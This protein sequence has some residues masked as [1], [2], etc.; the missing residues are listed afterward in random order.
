MS[1]SATTEAQVN[2]LTA[3]YDNQRT[4]ANLHEIILNQSNVKTG[5]FG[6][7]GTFPV[8]GEIYAQPL[9]VAG[10]PIQGQGIR[11]VVYIATNHN[12][13][14]AI[15]ADAT[16][17]T[18]PLWQVNLGPAVPSSVLS[19]TDVL[20]EVGILSTPVIDLMRQAIYV[21]ADTLENGVPVF[22]LHALSLSDGNE[23]LNGPI[24]IAAKVNGNGAGSNG[25]GTL[26]FDGSISLQR[27]GLVLANGLMYLGF[28]SRG[29]LG[30]W[31][32]WFIAYDASNLQHQVA[33]LNTSPNGFGA[34]I[35]QAGRAP[36]VDEKGTIYVVTGNGDFD[37]TAD[38]GESVLKLSGADLTLL[39]W[40]TPDTFKDWND[41][42]L[43]LGSTG[44]ILLPNTNLV[45]TGGKS[46][47][48]FL[49]DGASMGHLGAKNTST[50]QNI[51]ANPNGVFDMA[52]W[53]GPSGPIAYVQEPAGSLQAYQIVA[54]KINGTMLSH[55]APA[56]ATVFTGIAVSASSSTDPAAI[57]WETTADDLKVM[58]P[59]TLHAF[60]ATD[61]TH[62]LWNSDVVP[63]DA[64]GRFAKF[65][66]PTVA[67]GRVYVPTFSN[68]LAIYGLLSSGPPT[69]ETGQPQITAVTHGASFLQ[70][71]VSPGELVAIFGANLGPAQL[72]GL[73]VGGNG[74]LTT[75]LSSTR[76]F[77]DGVPSPLLYTSA[78]QVGAIVPFRITA[79]TQVQVQYQGQLSASVTIPVAPAAPALFSKDGT[80]GDLGAILNQ[81]GTPNSFNAPAARGSIVMM[82]ATGLGQTNP[83]G[84]DGQIAANLPLPAPIL[85][86]TVLIDNQP[87]EVLYAGAAPGMVQGVFQINARVPQSA[88]PFEDSVVLELGKY[89]SPTTVTLVVK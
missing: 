68:Q 55:T 16:Q 44:A 51:L 69:P 22:H 8:D 72:T 59:G 1:F 80:G 15:D 13:V 9:Y 77:F 37:G 58:H 10:V 85:P 74:R 67:N 87:A 6:K 61:L 70:G 88:T 29:D 12:S 52:L 14:Y 33:V 62:E 35:W 27:P 19:I 89:S 20:P 84:N 65:V 42:D 31:H 17:S 73:Q 2:V 57:V 43:D 79:T 83:P 38:F 53:N 23:I 64:L 47:D 11:N 24:V 5:G 26:S 60:D 40:Y 39:D 32:G 49:I 56:T 75:T 81:D 25:D 36:V 71:A 34:S 82:Y 54:G 76:V 30:N 45:L 21:A 86:V 78:T 18:V 66:A 46:G 41:N 63:L 48:M 4:N 50:V 7:I 28:G 3:N